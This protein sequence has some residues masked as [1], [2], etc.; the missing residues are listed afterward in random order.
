MGMFMKEHD[1]HVTG[2]QEKLNARFAPSL[3]TKGHLG[4]LDEMVALQKEF[5]IFKEGRRFET[6]LAVLNIGGSINQEARRRFHLYLASLRKQK[7]NVT[8]KN[9]DAAI[10]GALIRNLA[11]KKPLPV[12]FM[13]HDM[14]ASADQNRVIITDKARPLFYM[15]QDYLVISLPVGDEPKAAVKAKPRKKAS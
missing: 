7:S 2:F 4:G 1:V 8:G 10:V 15:K 11:A 13:P 12:Y 14:S 5:G 9:G 3:G 6:S